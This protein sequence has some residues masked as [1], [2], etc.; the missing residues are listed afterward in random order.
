MGA[1]MESNLKEENP[2]INREIPIK[3]EEKIKQINWMQRWQT[4]EALKKLEKEI[5]KNKKQDLGFHKRLE[6][7]ISEVIEDLGIE[8]YEETCE[9]KA[10]NCNKKGTGHHKTEER[11]TREN[12]TNKSTEELEEMLINILKETRENL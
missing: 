1:N 5:K 10:K 12:L 2:P 6:E 11:L 3:G 9:C 7:A 4:K 8:Y